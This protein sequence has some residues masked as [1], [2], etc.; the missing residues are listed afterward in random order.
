MQRLVTAA[1]CAAFKKANAGKTIALVPTMGALHSGHLALIDTAKQHADVVVVSIF[2]N[3]LQFGPNEDYEQYPRPLQADLTQCELAKADAV[4]TPAA[5]ELYPNGL[6]N[7][8]ALL[9]APVLAQQAC[10]ASR[11]GHFAGVCTV[12]AKLFGWVQPNVAVFGQ[13]DAQQ[14]A[15]IKAMVADFNMPVQIIAHPIERHTSD[16]ALAG[17]AISSRNQYLTDP[18][19]KQAAVLLARWLVALHEYSNSNPNAM[20]YEA[21]G[22]AREQAFAGVDEGIVQRFALDYIVALDEATFLPVEKL[23]ATARVLIAAHIGAEGGQR[24][25]LIDNVHVG[26]ALPENLQPVARLLAQPVGV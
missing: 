11:P 13:K 15:I 8:S 7:T 4:F 25:R 10:G 22:K 3:P 5:E 2:V 21:Y 20:A 6:E 17:V 24:V 23:T 14:L 26:Q 18:L 1:D 12:V 19:D 9:P 16:E